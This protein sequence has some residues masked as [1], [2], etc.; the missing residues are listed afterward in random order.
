MCSSSKGVEVTEELD[1]VVG[2]DVMEAVAEHLEECVKN[3][4]GLGLVDGW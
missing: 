1:S 2:L 4:P 3:S